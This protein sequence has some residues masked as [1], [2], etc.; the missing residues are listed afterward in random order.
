MRS[1]LA[2]LLGISLATDFAFMTT[3]GGV[4]GYAASVYYLRRTGASASAATAVTATDQGMDVLFFVA[5]LPLAGLSL[6]LS[7]A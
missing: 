7:N 6:L 1:H 5:A 3:P 2:A 4:G